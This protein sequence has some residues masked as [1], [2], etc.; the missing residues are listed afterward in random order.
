MGKQNDQVV[1]FT[2]CNANFFSLCSDLITSI[3]AACG[4][5]PR[6]CILDVGLRPEQLAE[7]R[8]RV[9]VVIE[10]AWEL[11]RCESYPDGS[12]Q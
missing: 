10:P 9:E 3:R 11:G 4:E 2:A 5:L 7:L 12:V 8:K 1:F 6:M